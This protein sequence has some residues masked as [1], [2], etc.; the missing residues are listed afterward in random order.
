MDIETGDTLFPP[1]PVAL[2]FVCRKGCDRAFQSAPA[3]NMHEIRTHGKGWN[4]AK[5]FHRKKAKKYRFPSDDPAYRK[6]R[7]NKS[8]NGVT[9]PLAQ[10][11][12]DAMSEAA[13]AIIVA[14][15]VLRSVSIGLKL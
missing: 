8:K 2:P 14:A 12:T 1:E 7:Y 3:R 5:N 4:T 13:K 15:Q 10:T 6:S 11:N 9:R